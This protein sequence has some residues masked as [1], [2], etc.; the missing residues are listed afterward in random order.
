MFLS[1]QPAVTFGSQGPFLGNF[2]FGWLKYRVPLAKLNTHIYVVGRSGKGKSKFLEGL[3]WQLITSGHGCGLIDPHGDLA[4]NLLTLL[5]FQPT[6]PGK[7]P[8]LSD[9][10]NAA[11]L[12]YCEPGHKEYFIPMN[13]LASAD[14]PYTIAS[15]VI[16]AFQRTWNKEISR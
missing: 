11:K 13:V 14:E 5:A 6:G 7:R 15:N 8:W 9:P 4:N 10:E 2:D 1:K 16:E 3:L 12:V